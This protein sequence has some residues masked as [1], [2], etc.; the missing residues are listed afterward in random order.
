MAL[1]WPCG[2]VPRR[3]SD[4]CLC[5]A[6]ICRRRPFPVQLEPNVP[7]VPKVPDHRPKISRCCSARRG[8]P[9]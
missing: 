4:C 6:A 7:N 2:R 8:T 3:V 9:E 5:R 1:V